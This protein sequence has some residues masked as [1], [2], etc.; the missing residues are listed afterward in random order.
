MGTAQVENISPTLSYGVLSHTDTSPALGSLSVGMSVLGK[1]GLGWLLRVGSARLVPTCCG[2]ATGREKMKLR[3]LALD[4]KVT[5]DR[6]YTYVT[7]VGQRL[8]QKAPSLEEGADIFIS[9]QDV[10]GI[11]EKSAES[12]C[13]VKVPASGNGEDGRVLTQSGR[14][15]LSA[16]SPL[17]R[18]HGT[19][20]Q[21]WARALFIEWGQNQS[22]E[23]S[24]TFSFG[25]V[26]LG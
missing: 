6:F 21:R 18:S 2:L 24:G 1:E 19:P 12:E 10:R 25:D 9:S 22:P 11:S 5:G 8:S 20:S 14:S 7:I 23:N 17:F 16:L 13:L 15:G 4:H 3:E 26:L